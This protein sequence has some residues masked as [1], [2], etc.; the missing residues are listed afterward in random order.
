M[1]QVIWMQPGESQYGPPADSFR[2]RDWSSRSISKKVFRTTDTP[3]PALTTAVAPLAIPKV[4]YYTHRW[5]D[6]SQVPLS[7]RARMD[8]VE[9]ANKDWECKYF[10]GEEQR[11]FILDH[12]P[13][14]IEAYDAI[15][16]RY[17]PARADLFRYVA[18][19]MFG[20]VYMDTKAGKCKGTEI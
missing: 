13:E 14:V 17:G 8:A 16:S 19:Y 3:M 6:R 20:G 1:T 9:A 11:Q 18:I 4:L 2:L 12:M 7:L 15:D 10:G 5:M